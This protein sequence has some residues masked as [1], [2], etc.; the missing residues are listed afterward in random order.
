MSRLNLLIEGCPSLREGV[1]E[2]LEI[3][4]KIQ[5]SVTGWKRGILAKHHHIYSEHNIFL[6]VLLA[7]GTVGLAAIFIFWQ[8]LLSRF[9]R[10]NGVGLSLMTLL[11]GAGMFSLIF[12]ATNIL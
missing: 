12:I 7:V 9:E 3:F 2:R 1:A 8:C 5:C 4:G 11:M 6:S 10:P